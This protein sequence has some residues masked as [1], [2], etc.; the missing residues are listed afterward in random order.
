MMLDELKIP[1]LAARTRRFGAFNRVCTNARK[2]AHDA[3]GSI[4]IIAAVAITALVMSAGVAVDFGAAYKK[5]SQLQTIADSAAIAAARELSLANATVQQVESVAEKM[6]ALK[7]ADLG[8]SLATTVQVNEESAS[9]EV[10]LTENW[11][12]YF[13]GLFTDTLSP[14]T[15]DALARIAGSEK[16]CVVGLEGAEARGVHLRRSA[17]LT[18]NGCAVYANSRNSKAI[19]IDDSGSMKASLICAVGGTNTAPG[20]YNPDPTVDCPPFPDPLADR[21][22]PS[23]SLCDFQDF[24]VDAGTVTVSPGVYCGGLV[25]AGKATINFQPGIYIIKDGPLLAQSSSTLSGVNVGFYLTGDQAQ[26]NFGANTTISLT[27]PKDGDMAGLLFFEDRTNPS[28]AIH[29]ITSNNARLLL[30]TF[31]LPVNRL[32]I[33][34][35]APVA[36]QSAY[37]AIIARR[38]TLD[39]GPNLVLNSNYTATDIPVEHALSGVGGRIVLAR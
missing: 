20:G 4:A 15:T 28:G 8:A 30:G 33:D 14:I 17:S 16:V 31:Y 36:D 9:V 1:A 26:M 24:E 6:V 12:P 5:R 22:A 27:A 35:N 2:A 3:S 34:A 7:A 25:V 19:Q 32:F 18:A 23:G 21:P 39:A 37:T 29:R 11:Q 13:A 10:T 38:L